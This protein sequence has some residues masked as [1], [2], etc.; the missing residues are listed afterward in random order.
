MATIQQLERALINADK[1]GDSDAARKIAAVLSRA[2]QD[3]SNQ[4]PGMAV[5]G[6]EPEAKQPSMLDRAIGTGETALAAVTSLPAQV[7]GMAGGTNEL[8]KAIGY[9]LAGIQ[10]PEPDVSGAFD[11]ASQAVQY[12]PK[13]QQGIEQ[14]Q[15]LGGVMENLAPLGGLG[16]ELGALGKSMQGLKAPAQVAAKAAA[17]AA[18]EAIQ[19]VGGAIARV[20]PSAPE[21]ATATREGGK[22][23]ESLGIR[24]LTS[25]YVPPSTATGKLTQRLFEKIP[26]TGTGGARAAQQSER[27]A[28]IKNIVAEYGADV[29]TPLDGA[30]YSSLTKAKADRINTM[31]GVKQAVKDKLPVSSPV[32]VSNT[33]NAFDK[34]I[35]SLQ[36]LNTPG[37]AAKVEALQQWRSAFE[38]NPGF[39]ALDK[40]RA[41]FGTTIKGSQPGDIRTALEQVSSRL[42]PAVKEDMQAFIKANAGDSDARRW[43]AA[44]EALATSINE[45]N[46]TRL[47][48][49]L[50]SGQATPEVVNR[51]LF[52]QKPSEVQVLMRNLTPEGQRAAQAAVLQK[53]IRDAGGIE[54]VSPDKFL[55]SINRMGPQVKFVFQGKAADELQ[56]LQRALEFTRRAGQAVA[57]PETGAQLTLPAAITGVTGAVG[58]LPGLAAVGGI[59]L[60]G[61]AY[62]SQAVRNALLRLYKTPKGSKQEAAAFA[63]VQEAAQQAAKGNE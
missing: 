60:I 1:A 51:L 12:V 44:N 46:R 4:I 50:N 34:E 18:P 31:Q 13:T 20:A 8:V 27:I 55:N 58:G 16:A 14:T 24:T 32:P 15:A 40:I 29:D 26:V 54:N 57:N 2:R 43:A 30:I 45:T 59:G 42:Y 9:K 22:A 28:A 63:A 48:A 36:S 62:E 10:A 38:K 21:V 37:A 19:R 33:L 25:D 56:G 11:R 3:S 39:D 35:Q 52:S 23:A 17:S 6:T 5:E 47:R 53:A 49:V 7:A 61:R 41:E